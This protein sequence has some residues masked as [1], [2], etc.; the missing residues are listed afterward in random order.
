[1]AGWHVRVMQ[2][3]IIPCPLV[4]LL[5]GCTPPPGVSA[6]PVGASAL[7]GAETYPGMNGRLY[8]LGQVLAREQQ[9]S[10]ALQEQLDQRGQEIEQL[11]TEVQDMRGRETD[12]RTAL[13]RATA[14]SGDVAAPMLAAASIALANGSATGQDAAADAG[15]GEPAR[16]AGDDE[17]PNEAARAA[18]IA[19]LRAALSHEQEQRQAAETQ[20]VRLKEETSAPP[21]EHGREPDADL[22]AAQQEITDLR[23]A[24]ADERTTRARLADD[25]RA[26]QQRAA[27]DAARGQDA[28]LESAELRARLELLQAEQQAA[29]DSFNRS[30]GAS[31]GRVADLEQ[32]LAAAR[33]TVSAASWAAASDAASN[34]D[35]A[36][37]RAENA[38][39]RTRLDEEHHRTEEL[40]K[41]LKLAARVTDLIF[42][43]QAQ[44]QP[45]P[46]GQPQ[47]WAPQMSAPHPE[48]WLDR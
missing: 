40:A 47:M 22:T 6:A 18:E 14:G 41:K 37:I 38:A 5:A 33:A 26:L 12:L 32:Q 27:Q 7:V 11:R 34:G 9:R 15:A 44:A 31:Q 2:S 13:E 35:G 10:A 8:A 25:L 19:S 23:V 20:L 21:Y 36:S 45:A 3:A 29:V 42:K 28:P 43:M 48:P 46:R 24:L 16:G 30:L 1:M 39:L 17:R 4:F